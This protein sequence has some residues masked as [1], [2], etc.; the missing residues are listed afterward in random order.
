MDSRIDLII[1]LLVGGRVGVLPGLMAGSIIC[2]LLQFAYNEI[3]VMRV[4][5][6]SQTLGD[7]EALPVLQPFKPTL[8]PTPEVSRGKPSD[9]VGTRPQSF[10]DRVFDWFGF[11]RVAD[12]EYLERLKRQRDAHLIR[13]AELEKELQEGYK[14]EPKS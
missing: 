11:H 3:G 7:A 6:V 9:V 14:E 13:I 8:P 5:Y 4:K 1:V 12:D 2:T 10:S